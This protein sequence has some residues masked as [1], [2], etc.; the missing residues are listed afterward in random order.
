MEVF[1]LSGSSRKSGLYATSFFLLA[2]HWMGYVNI[3]S[4][5]CRID[6]RSALRI[7]ELES[8]ELQVGRRKREQADERRLGQDSNL[9]GYASYFQPFV[10]TIRL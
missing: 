1:K 5:K 8:L 10:Y 9:F 7:L 4:S 2:N 3:V 6:F